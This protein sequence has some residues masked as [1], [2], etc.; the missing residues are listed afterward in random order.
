VLPKLA[1]VDIFMTHGKLGF[2]HRLKFGVG[3]FRVKALEKQ[4]I[5]A[6]LNTWIPK[7]ISLTL[8]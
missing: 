2:P 7:E 8:N 1:R 6:I 5:F 3:I 4:V